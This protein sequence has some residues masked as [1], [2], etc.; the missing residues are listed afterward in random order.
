MSKKK[1]DI[2]VEPINEEEAHTDN[3]GG[4]VFVDY[5]VPLQVSRQMSPEEIERCQELA[6]QGISVLWS[7]EGEVSKLDDDNGDE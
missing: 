7:E 1:T 5:F 6:K 2:K 4:G 3:Q